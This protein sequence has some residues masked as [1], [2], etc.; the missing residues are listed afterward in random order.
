MFYKKYDQ[1]CTSH[2]KQ[3]FPAQTSTPT[4]CY[5]LCPQARKPIIHTS[6]HI[7]CGRS[8]AAREIAPCYWWTCRRWSCRL[9]SRWWVRGSL[10]KP[11]AINTSR[12]YNATTQRVAAVIWSCR[13]CV[14]NIDHAAK[15]IL[16]TF[17]ND[18]W[19]PPDGWGKGRLATSGAFAA[20]ID[21]IPRGVD[22]YHPVGGANNEQ[23]HIGHKLGVEEDL[24]IRVGAEG[25]G[26]R[27]VGVERD[28][29]LDVLGGWH[30]V[31]GRRGLL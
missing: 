10:K 30:S 15:Q 3:V 17:S 12:P 7:I 24:V 31:L 23:S 20:W 22:G 8:T 27:C 26:V 16:T 25:F 18:R 4:R 11:S 29:G 14:T 9:W 6:T 2:R 28:V 19:A 5:R 13:I 1:R 21:F